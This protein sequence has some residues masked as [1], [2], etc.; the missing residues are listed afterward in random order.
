MK[1]QQC[2][3]C[4]LFTTC[5]CEQNKNVVC[6]TKIY[7]GEIMSRA[8]VKPAWVFMYICPILNEC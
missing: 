7:F 2:I 8:T 3:L 5:N 1:N 4:V 6:Y